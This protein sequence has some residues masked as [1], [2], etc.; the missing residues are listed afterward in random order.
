MKFPNLNDRSSCLRFYWGNASLLIHRMPVSYYASEISDAEFQLLTKQQKLSDLL[1][2]P[3]MAGIAT[4]EFDGQEYDRLVVEDVRLKQQQVTIAEKGVEAAQQNIDQ[5]NQNIKLANQNIELSKQ[6]V[7]QAKLTVEQA[8]KALEVGEKQIKDASIYAPIDGNIVDLNVREGDVVSGTGLGVNKLIY[9]M[10]TS[11]IHISAQ[12][13][14]IDI[15]SVA[16][17]QKVIIHLDS[18]PQI[19]YDGIVRTVSLL[20]L[21]NVQNAGVVVYEV[22]IDFVNPPPPR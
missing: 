22:K 9:I 16:E 8:N 18:A 5:A 19:N 1:T 11:R 12:I 3:E 15:P 13:D 4:Y 20:P 10:D 21:V 7:E 2:G 17:G 6:A 14:E